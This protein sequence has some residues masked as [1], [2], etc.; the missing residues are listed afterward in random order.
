M[1]QKEVAAEK[2]RFDELYQR[3]FKNNKM[4]F[5]GML[6][7][8]AARKWPERIALLCK[9]E[10]ITF[11]E[12][13]RR[14]CSVTKAL[15]DTGVGPDDRV[16]LWYENSIE[17]FIAYYG[18]WQTGAVVAALNVF[19]HEKEF[20]HILQDAQ[21]KVVIISNERLEELSEKV[22]ATLPTLFDTTF[23]DST[24]QK[25]DHATCNIPE[26]DPEAL[27]ALLYTSGTTGMPKGVMLSSK[28]I[29]TNVIQCLARIDVTFEDR[30][31][32]PVPLFHSLAQNT[33]VWGSFYLGASAIII[34]KVERR[35]LLQGLEKK[36]TIILAVPAL[37]GV[38]CM[39]RNL[40]FDSIRYFAS[41]GDALP[42]K[43]R[44]A[45]S[46]IYRR[47]ICNGYGLTET[48]PLI[49]A[50]VTEEY[51]SADT[52]GVPVQRL[53]CTIRGEE[54]K[55]IPQGEVGTLWV[56]GDN[57]MLGYYKAPELTAKVLKDNW[58][59]TGDL[60]R[61]D[62]HGRLHIVGREKDLIIH[63]GF[64]I[65]PQEIENVL[66]SHPS[67]TQAAVIGVTNGG[68]EEFP[69]AFVAVK[70]KVDN[71]EKELRKLCKQH[72]ATYK[73]PRTFIIKKSLPV[74]SLAKVDK[75]A[76]KAQYEQGH[77]EEN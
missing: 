60:A 75:K 20:E 44:S 10:S 61:I 37:Y 63:K 53:E 74:T 36:P 9:D 50:H 11:A 41:G 43:I 30:I 46:L 31:Y 35:Y 13:Y 1:T 39:M 62:K 77:H 3:L 6:L 51:V 47:K 18:I 2:A 71:L 57:I 72:L 42:D 56:K 17:F 64:N 32:M 25:N 28:N 66:L 45:F 65:Y 73:I 59:N 7:Q 16:C 19:L 23:I 52:V 14:A 49:A 48:S 5:A 55:D 67:V 34:P 69:V 15:Q 76:L 21:P 38:F 58:F 24:A 33:A 54:G 68:F 27:A 22:R 12:L 40:R 29:F 70:E 4:M 8:R 26:K